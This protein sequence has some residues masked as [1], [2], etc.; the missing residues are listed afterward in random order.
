[1]SAAIPPEIAEAR[2][3]KLQA[4]IQEHGLVKVAFA[5]KLGVEGLRMC[6]NSKLKRVIA[7]VSLELIHYRLADKAVWNGQEWQKA[8]D[9]AVNDRKLKSEI[10]KERKAKL[11]A[12]NT[13][14]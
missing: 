11:R 7:D 6:A 2:T 3:L 12:A 13:K 10:E 1:M 14:V 4:Y 5:A 8:Q 9:K